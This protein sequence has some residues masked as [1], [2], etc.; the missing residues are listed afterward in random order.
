M[1]PRLKQEAEAKKRWPAPL[2]L[3]EHLQDHFVGRWAGCSAQ[4]ARLLPPGL[5]YPYLFQASVEAEAAPIIQKLAAIKA[6]QEAR[7]KEMARPGVR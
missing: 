4:E 7:H 1:A 2:D 5:Y 6:E 3:S